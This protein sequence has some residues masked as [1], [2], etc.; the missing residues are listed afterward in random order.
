MLHIT[1]RR[2]LPPLLLISL[3]LTPI[4]GKDPAL[5]SVS[6]TDV[7]TVYEIGPHNAFTD[8]TWFKG[9]IYLAFRNCPDGHMV[10]PTSRIIIL[11]STNGDD[12]KEVYTF[13]VRDRDTRDPHFVV[14][15]DELFLYTGT[16]YCGE[17][18]PK[19]RNMNQMLG[20]GVKTSD[21]DVWTRPFELKGTY[22]HYVWRGATDSKSVYLCARRRRG[23]MEIPNL[24]RHDELVESR[25]L[26]SN[27]GVSFKDV[28]HFQLKYGD[29]TSFQFRENGEIQAVSRQGGNRN[30]QL[31]SL[32]KP[33]N[34]P[35]VIDLGRYIGGPLLFYFDDHI[36]VSGRNIR[37]GRVYTNVSVLQNNRLY[38]L[39]DLPS[40]GD[41]SYPGMV[42]LCPGC[43]LVSWYSSHL[44][45]NDGRSKTAIF[46]AKINIH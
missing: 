21:G 16:W 26:R 40:S 5:P 33:Y 46:T 4:Y 29:E 27:D 25:I 10:H 38:D 41:C 32:T 3:F 42:A 35:K 15:R 36:L 37:D 20:F 45:T 19:D 23:F 7:N 12:W 31:I 13:S 34:D 1:T 18:R 24:Q 39:V 30:A 8:M 17:A 43:I 6:V 11:A 44:K 9:K 2:T 14:F 28:G 22:G